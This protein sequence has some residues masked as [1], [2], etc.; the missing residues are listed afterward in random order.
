MVCASRSKPQW[1]IVKVRTRGINQDDKV[2]IDY[3]RN[4][5][6]WKRAHAPR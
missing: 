4:V 6:V 1:G 2:V 3:A 5:M